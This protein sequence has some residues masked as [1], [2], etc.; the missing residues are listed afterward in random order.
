MNQTRGLWPPYSSF[1]LH[2]SCFILSN[3]KLAACPTF[4][5]PFP[6]WGELLARPCKEG[7]VVQ[8]LLCREG[9]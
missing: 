8:F 6:S 1:M 7:R 9:A 3:G 5:H 2:A 4:C